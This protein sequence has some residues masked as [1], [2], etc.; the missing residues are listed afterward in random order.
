MPESGVSVAVGR[1]SFHGSGNGPLYSKLIANAVFSPPPPPLSCLGTCALPG[2]CYSYCRGSWALGKVLLGWRGMGR[3]PATK[4]RLESPL[5]P[6][7]RGFEGR[8][9]SKASRES[10]LNC[11]CR[12]EMWVSC[13]VQS[14]SPLLTILRVLLLNASHCLCGGRGGGGSC[15]SRKCRMKEYRDLL[16]FFQP[17]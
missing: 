8:V 6:L 7:P 4:G 15:Y 16:L 17:Y 13:R 10:H 3:V 2:H 9:V 14:E 11:R 1:I 5:I 12:R